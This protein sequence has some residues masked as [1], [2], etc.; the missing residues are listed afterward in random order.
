MA[1]VSVDVRQHRLVAGV[2]YRGS[3][4]HWGDDSPHYHRQSLQSLDLR[5]REPFWPL[6]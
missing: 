2:S 5:R 3:Y 6:C 4:D 1:Y